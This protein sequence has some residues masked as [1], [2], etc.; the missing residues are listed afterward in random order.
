MRMVRLLLLLLL[1]PLAGCLGRHSEAEMAALKAE[2]ARK[3]DEVC[4]SYGAKPGTDIYIQCRMHQAK[5]RDDADNAIGTSQPV[6]VNNSGGSQPSTPVLQP[7]AQP[8]RCQSMN[9]GMGRVH[10]YCN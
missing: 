4:K 5:A 3:D 1:L 6:I 2:F 10:T 9:V 8:T 7:I